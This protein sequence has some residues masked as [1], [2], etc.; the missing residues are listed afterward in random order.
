[1][2]DVPWEF[3][4]K[5]DDGYPPACG[6]Q[7]CFMNILWKF[8]ARFGKDDHHRVTTNDVKD[9]DEIIFS[10]I[11]QFV[12]AGDGVGADLGCG[13]GGVAARLS[14]CFG[15]FIATDIVESV[16]PQNLKRCEFHVMDIRRPDIP[17]ETI[18][19]VLVNTVLQIFSKD[20]A[21]DVVKNVFALVKKGG[22][23]ILG[24]VPFEPLYF[25]RSISLNI[26]AKPYILARWI[27]ARFFCSYNY[28][29]LDFFQH[30]LGP[31]GVEI[32]VVPLDSRHPYCGGCFNIVI[33]KAELPINLSVSPGMD[34][35]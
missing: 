29:D 31:L 17:V 21:R 1:M 5:T 9:I 25:E 22:V 18:D 30:I 14:S 7:V 35:K 16:K 3:S 24:E 33:K 34:T 8:M 13:A 15:R 12:N 26:L 32:A 20:V 27:Y 10:G 4:G 6:Q 19:F 2:W 23:L 28:F 11:E